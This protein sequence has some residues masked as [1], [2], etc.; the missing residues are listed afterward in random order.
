MAKTFVQMAFVPR[1][2]YGESTDICQGTRLGT[3]ILQKSVYT[4][5]K[6][7]GHI[8]LHYLSQLKC[9]PPSPLL[10]NSSFFEKESLLLKNLLQPSKVT[11]LFLLLEISSRDHSSTPW[12]TCVIV[13]RHGS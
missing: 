5:P 8:C 7:A 1:I 12:A 13:V 9:S 6:N 3:L 2:N 10:I 11:L 4:Q